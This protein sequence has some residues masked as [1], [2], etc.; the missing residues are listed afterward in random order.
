MAT[1]ALAMADARRALNLTPIGRGAARAAVGLTIGRATA[2]AALFAA[3]EPWG[4]LNDSLSIGLAWAGIGFVLALVGRSR[5]R[6]SLDDREVAAGRSSLPPASTDPWTG[7]SAHGATTSGS[8]SRRPGRAGGGPGHARAH[9][10]RPPP[11]PS[12]SCSGCSSPSSAWPAGSTTPRAASAKRCCRPGPTRW[13]PRTD[14]TRPTGLST[15]WSSARVLP[16]SHV[17]SLFLHG[18]P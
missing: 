10:S 3:G 5:H 15:A 8:C 2:L 9:P 13:I 7:S 16:R 17:P 14:P 1:G 6:D 4:T 18:D 11:G 12:R